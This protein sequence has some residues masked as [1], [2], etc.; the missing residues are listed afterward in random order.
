MYVQYSPLDELT[1]EYNTVGYLGECRIRFVYIDKQTLYTSY[2]VVNLSNIL[3][4]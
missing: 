2:T 3:L 1:C 4:L